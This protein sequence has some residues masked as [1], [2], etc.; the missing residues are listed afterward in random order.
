MTSL[1]SCGVGSCGR[2][3]GIIGAAAAAAG[4][5][6]MCGSMHAPGA[7][8]QPMPAPMAAAHQHR[9]AWPPTHPRHL[10]PAFSKGQGR[11]AGQGDHGGGPREL[12][13]SRGCSRCQGRGGGLRTGQGVRAGRPAGVRLRR[14]E[15]G[16][17]AAEGRLVR[18]L[19]RAV[20][21]Q[22]ARHVLA[23]QARG[24]GAHVVQDARGDLV[25]RA[26]RLHRGHEALVQLL[27]PL[28]LRARRAAASGGAVPGTPHAPWGEP[29]AAVAEP[30]SAPG[31][32]PSQGGRAGTSAL[33]SRYQEPRKVTC[34]ASSCPA[35]LQKPGS[36][37]PIPWGTTMHL[38]MSDW[39]RLLS[40]RGRSGGR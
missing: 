37:S 3:V 40:A 5:D 27:R 10:G 26:E 22:V 20:L 9:T 25:A 38:C 8:C 1:M 14:V 24:R 17:V 28:H 2:G 11:R 23:R 29:S 30:V 33:C 7:A 18:A 36:C 19:A 4:Q 39:R 21:L 15:R 16:R 32:G 35:T 13:G 34:K 12:L 6:A 31:P